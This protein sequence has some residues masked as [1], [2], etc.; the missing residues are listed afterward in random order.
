VLGV[1]MTMPEE[2]ALMRE[3]REAKPPGAEGARR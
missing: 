2:D 3:E 1:T